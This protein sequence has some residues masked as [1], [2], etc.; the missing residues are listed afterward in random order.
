MFSICSGL[1]IFPASRYAGSPPTQVNRKKTSSTT[2]SRVG[3]VCQRRRVTYASMESFRSIA[4]LSCDFLEERLGRGIAAEKLA[5]HLAGGPLPSPCEDQLA[6]APSDRRIHELLP[7]GGQHVEREYLRPHVAVVPGAVAA[8]DVLEGSGKLRAGDVA[9]RRL[10]F[11]PD[12]LLHRIDFAFAEKRHVVRRIEVLPP[13]LD[14]AAEGMSG[15][16]TLDQRVID[17]RAAGAMPADQPK[18]LF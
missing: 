16:Q 3:I 2:P 8:D 15:A 11:H 1:E 10:A 6:Q 17:L 12:P 5:H 18:R 9:G 4:S 7:V 13:V 14:A